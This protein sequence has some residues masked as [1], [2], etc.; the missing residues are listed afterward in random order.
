MKNLEVVGYVRSEVGTK[1]SKQLRAEGNVPCVLYGADD[2]VHFHVPMYLFKAL[3]YSPEAFWVKLN[4]EGTEYD[5][6]MQDIQFHPVSEMIMHVDFFQITR[7]VKVTLDIP[8]VTVGLSPGVKAG[9]NLFVK[10]RKLSVRAIPSK[11]PEHIEADIS[12]LEMGE[13]LQVKDIKLEDGVFTANPNV[14]VIQITRPRAAEVVEEVEGEEGEE[15]EEGAE[16]PAAEG[17]DAPAPA[18]E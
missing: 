14:T 9:G 5:A 3:V 7:G 12:E 16:A 6:V 4:I 11:L 1:N 8:V 13:T 15:G 17:G 10:N 2:H 18:A